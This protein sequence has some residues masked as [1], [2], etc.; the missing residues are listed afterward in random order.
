MS[1]GSKIKLGRMVSLVVLL[2]TRWTCIAGTEDPPTTPV[3]ASAIND[4]ANPY[5]VITQRNVFKLNPPPPP[6]EPDKG[7]P[8]VIPDVYLSGFMRTGDP[9]KVLLAVKVENPDPH[10]HPITCYLT[11]GEGD[12]KTVGSGSKQ[13]VVE[14]VKAYADQGKADIINS[15]TPMTLSLKDSS[16]GGPA[17]ALSGR[18]TNVVLRKHAAPVPIPDDPPTMAIAPT[19]GENPAVGGIAPVAVAP[20][21]YTFPSIDH[22]PTNNA[23]T[24]V[25]GGTSDQ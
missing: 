18:K 6:P 13:G 15:G 12:K 20:P 9:W 10:G 22:D 16:P 23:N 7:P 24:I 14:L 3:I 19:N 2:G 25:T 4:G 1:E 8:P 11:L 17:A 5:W 21:V